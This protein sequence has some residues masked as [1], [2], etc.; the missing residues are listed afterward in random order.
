MARMPR[1]PLCS[2]TS[3]VPLRDRLASVKVTTV[4]MPPPFQVYA[5]RARRVELDH[6][7][8]D[9][10]VE[11]GLRLGAELELVSEARGEVG[12]HQPVGDRFGIGDGFPDAVDG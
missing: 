10:P 4:S 8:I 12:G 11:A 1:K 6:F 2:R 7:A 9:D 5:R 3:L